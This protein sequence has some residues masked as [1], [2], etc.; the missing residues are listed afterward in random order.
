[1]AEFPMPGALHDFFCS[2]RFP[3]EVRMEHLWTK[4]ASPPGTVPDVPLPIGPKS[5]CAKGREVGTA[6]KKS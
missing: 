1:M 5:C 2:P 3:S 4:V 6:V